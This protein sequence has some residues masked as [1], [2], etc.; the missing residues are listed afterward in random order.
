ML[1]NNRITAKL[2]ASAALAETAHPNAVELV[3]GVFYK[4]F[5]AAQNAGFKVA[6]V[7]ALHANSGSSQVCR[8]HVRCLKV[9]NYDFKMNPWAKNS[10]HS[11][12][13]NWIFVKI[14]AERWS[15]FFCVNKADCN[16]AFCKVRKDFQKRFC[17]A[18]V[19]YVKVFYVCSANPQSFF[20]VFYPL[21]YLL[22]MG[23]ICNVQSFWGKRI[24]HFC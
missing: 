1:K 24:F 2:L 10:L 8:T 3:G 7:F 15:W 12:Y 11:F 4:V 6:G 16:S 17:A 22:V 9:K 18:T 21:N 20:Y 23:F 13:Q 5:V 19:F 14:L